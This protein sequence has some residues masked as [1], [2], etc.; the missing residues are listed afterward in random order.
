[1]VRVLSPPEAEEFIKKLL[2]SNRYMTTKEIE[3]A[4]RSEGKRCPDETVLFLTKLRSMG[5]I[6]GDISQEK[7]GW[8]W[9]IED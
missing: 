6:R 3:I 1:M 7:R 9:W 4:A 5:I 8:I 2:K